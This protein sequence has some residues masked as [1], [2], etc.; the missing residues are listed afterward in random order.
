MDQIISDTET[1]GAKPT[2]KANAKGAECEA[3]KRCVDAHNYEKL[4]IARMLF[5]SPYL[6]TKGRQ[7]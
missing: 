2:A 5:G 7:S 3:S 4:C 6:K 1:V